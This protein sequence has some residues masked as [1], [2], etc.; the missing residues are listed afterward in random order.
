MNRELSTYL[1][2][3]RF[4]AAVT[5]FLGHLEP[6][7]FAGGPFWHIGVYLRT[8]VIIFFVLSGYVIAF[9]TDTKEKTFV[10]YMSCRVSRLGSIVIPALLLTAICDCIG[11][12]VDKAFYIHGPMPLSGHQIVNYLLSFG[13]LQ[14]VWNLN[15]NP[16]TNSPFWSL[17]YEWM[18]Y[19]ICGVALFYRKNKRIVYI[20]MLVVMAGPAITLLMPIWLLGYAAYF[21]H[22]KQHKTR[23]VIL[24]TCVSITSLLLI[25]IIPYIKIINPII[26]VEVLGIHPFIDYSTGILFSLH[27]MFIVP[28]LQGVKS[29][30]M[31]INGTVKWLS[32]L[33]FSMYLF[34]S[35]LIHICAVLSPYKEGTVS[36]TMWLIVLPALIIVTLGKWCDNKKAIF[37][38]VLK[39]W[40]TNNMVKRGNVINLIQ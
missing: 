17:S 3:V 25:I 30:L 12:K 2:L 26:S 28:L 29:Y 18:Y 21:Y 20:I 13:L 9:V 32:S 6:G 8:S 24:Y 1:D 34:H 40:C 19:L 14:N 5:V 7:I 27:I 10:D 11:S 39:R 37:K 31:G 4:F 36:R 16:G 23:R 22:K 15:L 38:E 33:T 35:P